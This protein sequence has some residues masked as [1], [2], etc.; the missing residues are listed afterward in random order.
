MPGKSKG[1]KSLE[2][3]VTVHGV[4][5]S[6]TWLNTYTDSKEGKQVIELGL[7]PIQLETEVLFFTLHITRTVRENV[8]LKRHNPRSVG[9]L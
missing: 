3:C 9:R 2:D 8:A 6:Q 4:A 5:K 7:S 1:Q